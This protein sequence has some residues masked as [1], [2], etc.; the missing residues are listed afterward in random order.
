MLIQLRWSNQCQ[1]LN[2]GLNFNP[3]QARCLMK[4]GAYSFHITVNHNLWQVNSLRCQWITSWRL[5]KMKMMVFLS[6]KSE[7]NCDFKST[8]FDQAFFLMEESFLSFLTRPADWLCLKYWRD[9]LFFLM[10]LFKHHVIA[11]QYCSLSAL[12][13]WLVVLWI[14]LTSLS[15]NI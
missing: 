14:T 11:K 3:D 13:S 9:Q 15:R 4:L 8:T 10:N 7:L 2:W 6:T 5:R 1:S 12:V